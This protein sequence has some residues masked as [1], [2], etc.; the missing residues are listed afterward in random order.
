[1]LRLFVL[2]CICLKDDQRINEIWSSWCFNKFSIGLRSSKKDEPKEDVLIVKTL[3]DQRYEWMLYGCALLLVQLFAMWIKMLGSQWYHNM[4]SIESEKIP[5]SLVQN[6]KEEKPATGDF[7]L[8]R[9]VGF[10][11]DIRHS[12]LTHICSKCWTITVA[13]YQDMGLILS[14]H[15]YIMRAIIISLGWLW[16]SGVQ[17]CTGSYDKWSNCGVPYYQHIHR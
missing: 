11:P 10:F 12:D 3:I 7:S 13:K 9:P 15:K 16:V 17:L 8:D 6:A 2:S 4:P 1:M 5:Y 14:R